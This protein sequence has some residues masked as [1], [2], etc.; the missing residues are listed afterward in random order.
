MRV[1]PAHARRTSRGR[2]KFAL[3]GAAVV[4]ITA[5]T[6][7]LQGCSG[8][9]ANNNTTTAP[10]P[11]VPQLTAIPSSIN[12]STAV[13]GQKNTQ[14]VQLS[15]TGAG[16]L[17]VQTVAVTGAAFSV[18]TAT[19]PL[20][21]VAGTSQNITV[22]FAPAS[23]SAFSGNLTITSNDPNSPLN[24]ALQGTGQAVSAALQFTPASL[25]FGNTT[26]GTTNTQSATLQ[27]TGNASVT[28]SAVTVTGAGFGVS[29][30]SSGLTL[31]PQQQVPFQLS[32]LPSVA[33]TASGS[34]SVTGSGLSAPLTMSLTGNGQTSSTSNPHSV[35]LSW[36]ASTS[37]VS[38]YFVYRGGVSGGPYSRVNSSQVATLNYTDSTV[39]AGAQY[40]YVVTAVDPS[41]A[42][43]A[44]S[45]EVPATIPTP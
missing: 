17:S 7:H 43:S 5:A 22:A 4:L 36:N 38:G 14:T 35:T 28:L 6:L 30:L 20:S 39:Q 24:I 9:V 2:R 41:G 26:V 34:L 27:N 37:T 15:N 10:P 25:N 45:N 33:G 13:V 23:A 11:S 12:F 18:T 40:F 29:S 31:A 32:F 42:E 1:R 8:V 21:I 19:L 16:T 44:Y 3:R